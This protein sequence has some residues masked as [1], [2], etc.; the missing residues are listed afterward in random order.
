MDME[1][2]HGQTVQSTKASIKTVRK[3]ER[4][5]YLSLMVAS[6]RESSDRMKYQDMANTFGLMEKP[7]KESG[8]KIK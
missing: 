6:M 1:L 4:A 8:R 7:T 3:M 2:N 5:N